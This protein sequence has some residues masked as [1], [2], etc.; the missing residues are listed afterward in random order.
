MSN[1]DRDEIKILKFPNY[2]LTLKCI[3]LRYVVL[4]V[5]TVSPAGMVT[6]ESALSLV[7]IKP[8][9]TDGCSFF[10]D[11]TFEVSVKWKHCCIAHDF[12]Y[13]KGGTYIEREHADDDLQRCVSNLGEENISALMWLGV[14]IGGSP[15]F[16][17]SY[18]WGYGWPES[19]GFQPLSPTDKEKV[20]A[21]VKLISSDLAQ[22]LN[23]NKATEQSKLKE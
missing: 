18:R 4:S 16:S 1:H 7:D 14:R 19:R 12:A 15:N 2:T 10:P 17:T 13:W 5:L 22:I 3:L 21:K 6:A 20:A 11:G 8:F 23:L 9:T